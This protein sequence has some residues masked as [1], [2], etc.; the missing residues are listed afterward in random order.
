MKI[1]ITRKS[2]EN[3]GVLIDEVS[4]TVKHEIRKTGRWI[5]W[6]IIRN[7]RCFNVRKYVHWK[8]C[9][10]SWKRCCKSRKKK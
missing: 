3:S 6:H 2:L 1:W 10:E 7:F 8:K 4:E 5:S 9:N